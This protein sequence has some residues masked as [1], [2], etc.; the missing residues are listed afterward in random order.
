MRDRKFI[1]NESVTA[2][3]QALY[4]HVVLLAELN[5]L[6]HEATCSFRFSNTDSCECFFAWLR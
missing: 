4:C 1:T 2:L 5:P 3:E 6:G